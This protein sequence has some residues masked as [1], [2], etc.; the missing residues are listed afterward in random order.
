M[1]C[2]C[3]FFFW[4]VLL[5]LYRISFRFEAVEHRAM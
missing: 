4:G 3:V 1:V 2:V 5:R